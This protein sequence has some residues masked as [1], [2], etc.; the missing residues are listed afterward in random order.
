MKMIPW[1]L[2]GKVYYYYISIITLGSLSGL[3]RY[4]FNWKSVASLI[5]M[6]FSKCDYGFSNIADLYGFSYLE[7]V[8]FYEK[9]ETGARE[10]S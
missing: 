8:S 10:T 7:Q 5:I 3:S 9:S 4:K 2:N 1:R 6:C